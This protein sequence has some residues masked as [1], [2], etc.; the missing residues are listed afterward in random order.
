M[1]NMKYVMSRKAGPNLWTIQTQEKPPMLAIATVTGIHASSRE[2]KLLKDIL[3]STLPLVTKP[4]LPWPQ[5]QSLRLGLT[6]WELR[7]EKRAGRR[8]WWI[9]GE[10]LWRSFS[11]PL[12]S[13]SYLFLFLYFNIKA[14]LF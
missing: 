9:P 7:R 10:D 1:E 2:V 3:S 13:A 4:P 5:S 14:I 8:T 11:S 6:R 12:P